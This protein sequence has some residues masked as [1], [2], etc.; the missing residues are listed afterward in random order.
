[1]LSMS[2]LRF[3][4]SIIFSELPINSIVLGFCNSSLYRYFVL[5][6]NLL[7][8]LLMQMLLRGF[9]GN[10]SYFSVMY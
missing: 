3:V 2:C 7:L 8:I 9:V 6:A 4:L 1:M 5:N 10:V